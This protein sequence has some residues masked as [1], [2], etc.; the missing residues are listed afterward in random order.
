MRIRRNTI[1][2]MPCLPALVM[3]LA[4]GTGAPAS[5]GR[6]DRP[7]F[8]PGP[9]IAVAEIGRAAKRARAVAPDLSVLR[10]PAR[11]LRPG[12]LVT[13]PLF[14]GEEL[15]ARFDSA[16]PGDLRG[17]RS[18]FLIGDGPFSSASFVAVDDAVSGWI[19]VGA[20]QFALDRDG[21]GGHV[22]YE[23]DPAAELACATAPSDSSPF[24]GAAPK[25]FV[26]K[27]VLGAWVGRLDVMVPYTWEAEA[28]MG[29]EAG[30]LAQIELACFLTNE[31]LANAEVK[32]QV[33]LVHAYRVDI[34]E[35]GDGDALLDALA[36]PGGIPGVS[37]QRELHGADVVCL[38]FGSDHTSSGTKIAGK[39]F[40]ILC[41]ENL[42]GFT[43]KAFAIVKAGPAV[44]NYSFAHELGHLLGARHD[45]AADS[46]DAC[47]LAVGE[48]SRGF[49]TPSGKYRSLMAY[50]PTG[51]SSIRLNTWSNPNRFTPEEPGYAPEA[52]GDASAMNWLALNVAADAGVCDW[53]DAKQ[54]GHSLQLSWDGDK[55]LRSAVVNLVPKSDINLRA[56]SARTDAPAG[57]GVQM[58]AWLRPGGAE[59]HLLD[60]EK[61]ENLGVWSGLAAGP[62][63]PTEIALSS[64]LTLEAGTQYGL[65]VE[66]VPAAGVGAGPK[67][68]LTAG[69][70]FTFD[71]NDLRV[72]SLSG[73]MGPAFSSP[74]VEGRALNAV[75]AYDGA[76]GDRTLSTG[77]DPS[78]AHESFLFQI[79]VK[80]SIRLNSMDV[81]L[82]EPG[83]TS[84]SVWV[85]QGADVSLDAPLNWDLLASDALVVS[86]GPSAFTRVTLPYGP[87][88]PFPFTVGT[89]TIQV[90]VT[91]AEF[92]SQRLCGRVGSM[93]VAD[94]KV[95]LVAN[96]YYDGQL[97]AAPSAAPGESFSGAI[98]Y[99]T[100]KPS[101]DIDDLVGGATAL[102]RVD[103]AAPFESAF[104]LVSVKGAGP[105]ASPYGIVDLNEPFLLAVLATDAAGSAKQPV[106]LPAAASGFYLWS[107]GFLYP[108]LELT[109]SVARRVK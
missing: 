95:M 97:F 78:I 85:R 16:E 24:A 59:G 11:G 73:A 80:E 65:F 23:V 104:L 91:G 10:D 38:F 62:D 32:L 33:N 77:L 88:G 79:E 98:H 52:L 4:V 68:I 19:Q 93:T 40:D 49:V 75:I 29:G 72:T 60:V 14:D 66:L 84:V 37:M 27:S 35:D 87:G 83:M 36:L 44:S 96:H 58:R 20:R 50:N 42:D 99:S 100:A 15:V 46:E 2:S 105:M 74:V 39:A 18:R 53:K 48:F 102:F 26:E 67:L 90:R 94:D 69:G 28:A 8:E 56:I 3:T 70:P 9:P 6:P 86:E 30:M 71:N 89:Y 21:C 7:L 92:T 106:Y 17:I 5:P 101:L 25:S 31:S 63:D 108:S 81:L 54:S 103:E 61:W 43:L 107:Q 1:L 55:H 76:D 41:V 13:I 22:F 109:N 57:A 34:V 51:G 82:S 45:E 64:H 12:D 47:F